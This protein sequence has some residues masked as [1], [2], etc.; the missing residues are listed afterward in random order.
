MNNIKNILNETNKD[1]LATYI[2]HFN[3]F[4]TFPQTE[5]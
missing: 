2:T 3:S 1:L 4:L 5:V